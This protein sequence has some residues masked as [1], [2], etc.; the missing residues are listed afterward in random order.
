[1]IPT[2][3]KPI[4]VCIAVQSTKCIQYSLKKSIY[5][6]YR[7]TNYE[8]LGVNVTKEMLWIK[9]STPSSSYVANAPTLLH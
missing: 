9:V 2:L 5:A 4:K 8:A 6:F 1:M 7:N 3:V